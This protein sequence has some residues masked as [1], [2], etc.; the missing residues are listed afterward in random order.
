VNNKL[1]FEIMGIFFEKV[2]KTEK[3]NIRKE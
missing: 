3:E 2:K 1:L